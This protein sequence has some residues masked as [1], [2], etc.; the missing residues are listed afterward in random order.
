M[1]TY[2]PVWNGALDRA[3]RCPSLSTY[4]GHSPLA[5]VI[6]RQDSLSAEPTLRGR[7][8]GRDTHVRGSHDAAIQRGLR[9]GVSYRCLARQY[10]LSVSVVRR[11]AQEAARG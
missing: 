7:C 4:L 5:S 6:E 10:G 8:R 2:L 11:V 1:L 9:L 3:E